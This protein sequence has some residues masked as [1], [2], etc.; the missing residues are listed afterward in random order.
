MALPYQEAPSTPLRPIGKTDRGLHISW[1]IVGLVVIIAMDDILRQVRGLSSLSLTPLMLILVLGLLCAVIYRLAFRKLDL[2]R[3]SV[4]AAATVTAASSVSPFR[5]FALF[6]YASF[7]KPHT[8]DGHGHR[9]QDALE[10]FYKSQASVYDATRARLLRGREDMLALAAAQVQHRT[11]LDG[12]GRDRVWVDIGGGT[13]YN[14]EAMSQFVSVPDFFSRVYLV[15]LSPSLCEV[16]RQRFARLGWTNVT[17]V[18]QDARAFRLEDHEPAAASSDEKA[19]TTAAA[20]PLY[21]SDS[22]PGPGGVHLVTLSYSLSMIPEFYSVV[23]SLS[24]LLAPTGILAVVDFYVQ[25]IVDVAGRN[26]TGGVFNRHVNW[27]ARVFWRAW[28]EVDRVGL[29]A[30]RR[31]YLEYRCGTILSM[32]ERNYLLGGIPYYIWIGCQKELEPSSGPLASP[33]HEVIRRLDAAATESPYLSPVPEPGP[34]GVG[35]KAAA[36]PPIRSKAYES[37]IVNLSSR[38]PLP[39]YFYQNHHWRIHYEDQDPKHTRFHNEYIYAF[40]W[41]DVQAD[42]RLLAIGPDD[43]VLAITSAGDNILAY[44]LHHPKRIH[45]VDLN[46]AQN[47]LLELKVAAFTALASDEVWRLF[48]EG[49]HPAFRELLIARLSPHL[50]SRAFQYWIDH[51]AVFTRARGHGLHGTGGSRHAM[52]LARWLFRVA[53]LQPHVDRLCA[54][55]TLAEQR[56]IWHQRIRHVLL[57]RTLTRAVIATDRFLWKALG[58]PRAQRRMIEADFRARHA[59]SRPAPAPGQ[60]I[61][62]YLV[63]TLDP[64]VEQTLIGADNHFYLL[65]VQGRYTKRCHPAYLSADA[66]ATLSRPEAFDGLRIHTDE[67]CEVIRRIMPGTLTIAVVMDSMDWFEPD[68]DGGPDDAARQVAALNH[69]LTMGGRVLLRSAART[70]WYTAVFARLGFVA[71]RVS[72]RRPGTCIDRWDPLPLYYFFW[73]SSLTSDRGPGFAPINQ[74]QHHLPIMA[75]DGGD[76]K[77][78]GLGRRVGRAMALAGAA[79]AT[80]SDLPLVADNQRTPDLLEI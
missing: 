21:R 58:V 53:G 31:D 63:D 28:F 57:S 13:G 14:I 69:A 33:S 55:T 48:G 66:H 23:D 77:S 54:A 79:A 4:T 61:W 75:D 80:E 26:Y 67:I 47:H 19:T 34:S 65:C 15:D 46:P 16:A 11:S 49:R 74:R 73:C 43:V 78:G 38:L 25:S 60:A 3:E 37:A 56:Q 59:G 17:I 76:E 39:A 45:A 1:A 51:A 42:Q 70:P 52:R 30:G 29:E 7:V 64:V 40:T 22:Q 72:E 20:E 71:S 35:A 27:L 44:A 50:S 68:A 8:G 36:Q 6:F 2:G 12:P 10:S 32:D 62:E 24:S 5:S 18:C 41:E 9:Q